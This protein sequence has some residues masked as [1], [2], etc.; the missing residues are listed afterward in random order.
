MKKLILSLAAALAC[1]LTPYAATPDYSDQ[2]NQLAGEFAGFVVGTPDA[3]FESCRY[4]EGMITFVVNP[5]SNIGKAY[6]A[7]PFNEAFFP[8]VLAKM[9][10]GNKEQGIRILDFLKETGTNFRFLIRMPGLTDY[11]EI[12][13]YPPDVKKYL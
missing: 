10:S 8:T 13:V 6:I 4:S 1:I 12:T 2:L 11:S 9:F 5:A 3:T 7:D